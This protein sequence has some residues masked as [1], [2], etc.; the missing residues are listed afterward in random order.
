VDE[1]HGG[2]EPQTEQQT[3]TLSPEARRQRADAGER[4]F[5]EKVFRATEP[6][7]PESKPVD[8]DELAGL[9]PFTVELKSN[10]TEV[11]LARDKWDAEGIYKA[12]YGILSSREPILASL[13][14]EDEADP[15][16]REYP[17]VV[18]GQRG[19]LRR[20]SD[21]ERYLT[22]RLSCG[23]DGRLLL[24]E[25]TRRRGRPR[26]EEPAVAE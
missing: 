23:N 24:K 11:V 22:E 20:V 16:R 15:L 3:A 1:N 10:P 6:K 8:S 17:V 12:H 4:A 21:D 7:Q 18:R 2:F 19:P 26:K 5:A 25:E 9:K 13:Q 14:P